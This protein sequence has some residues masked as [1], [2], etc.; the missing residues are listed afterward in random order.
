MRVLM[1]G[2]GTAGHVNPAIAIANTIKEY[3]P[4]SEIAFVCSHNKGDK[5]QDLVPRAGYKKPY[6]VRICG[7]KKIY[8]PANIKTLIYMMTSPIKAK[9]IIREFK[10]D[11]IIGTGGYACYPVARAGVKLGIPTVLH[12][13]NAIAGSAV[14]LL[15]SSV[16]I[17]MTNFESTANNLSGAKKVIRVGNPIIK[18]TK[19]TATEQESSSFKRSVLCFGGSLGAANLNVAF[20]EMLSHIANQYPDVEFIHASGKRDY[21]NMKQTYEDKG[22]LDRP[23]V[24]LLDYIYDMDKKMADAELVIS[25]AGAMTISEL[26]LGGKCAILVPS[27][28]VADNHQYKNAKALCD[29]NAGVMVQESEFESGKLEREVVKLLSDAEQRERLGKNILAFAQP[30]ANRI[31]YE[32]IKKL[33]AR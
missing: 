20:V 10:P 8:N 31:I 28:F 6:T 19:P 22:L 24:K 11:I 4:D 25:R 3:E 33:L 21:E 9:S 7:K 13:S 1:T 23:N 15:C 17:V 29:A 5:A 14:K 26:A 2:G 16:D 18:S 12:E 27:P 30:D 32:E